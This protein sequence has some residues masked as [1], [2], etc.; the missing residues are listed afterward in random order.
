M[1]YRFSFDSLESQVTVAVFD[2]AFLPPASEIALRMASVLD[3]AVNHANNTAEIHAFDSEN[4]ER[5]VVSA[6]LRI[7]LERALRNAQ[8]T[9]G[10][11]NP[12][13]RGDSSV[14]EGPWRD[15]VIESD[16]VCI[17]PGYRIETSQA[18]RAGLSE[19][20]AHRI[21]TQLN[22]PVMVTVGYVTSFAGPEPPQ[23]G[24]KYN[25]EAHNHLYDVISV[26]NNEAIAISFT[27]EHGSRNTQWRSVAVQARSALFADALTR[28]TQINSDWGIGKFRELGVNA[29]LVDHSGHAH[30]FGNWESTAEI[31]VNKLLDHTD[32]FPTIKPTDTHP[33]A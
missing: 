28:A 6:L 31:Q 18:A 8:I 25:A 12:L 9:Q 16:E 17:P 7:T 21:S 26:P 5:I 29:R 13:R 4:G 24:W 27:T 30:I 10:I 14:P 3:R 32:Q 19:D 1:L 2:K 11:L 15:I 33:A 23:G 20:I 22:I